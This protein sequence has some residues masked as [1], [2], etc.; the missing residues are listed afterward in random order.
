MV[1]AYTEQE[2]LDLR[3]IMVINL[4]TNTGTFADA[5]NSFVLTAFKTDTL[6]VSATGFNKVSLCFKDSPASVTTISVLIKLRRLEVQL[7]EVDVFPI[8]TYDEIERERAKLN[9][10]HATNIFQEISAFS[11]PITALY[12]RFSKIEQAKRKVAMWEN[13]DLKRAILKDLFRIYVKYDIINMSDN[14][15]DM[16]INY[17]NF[18]VEFIRSASQYELVMAI[19]QRY[20]RYERQTDYYYKR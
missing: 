20:E 11:S 16:F 3:Q 1:T 15:F 17:C 19:K 12:E 6:V 18:P 7:K 13:E 2:R 5:D 8:K 14:E 4:H 9:A 10:P